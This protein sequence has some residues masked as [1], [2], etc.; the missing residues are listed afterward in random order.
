MSRAAI[1]G[2]SQPV[3]TAERPLLAREI[4]RA[5]DT[6]PEDY[7][8]MILLAD[9]EELSYREIADVVGCPIGT[10]M[11]RLHRARKAMQK[12]LVPQAINLGIID[13]DED[14]E[15]S[16]T[17]NEAVSLD[18]FRAKKAMEGAG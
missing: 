15:Q 12:Q 18:A 6:L 4:Q 16:T 8:I 14:E 3:A 13:V 17:A 9:V 1:R 5:L 2:L 7:R 10:V 11:S